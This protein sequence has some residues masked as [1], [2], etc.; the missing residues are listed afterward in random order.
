MQACLSA[1]KDVESSFHNCVSPVKLVQACLCAGNTL[2]RRFNRR[3]GAVK[4]VQACLSARNDLEAIFTT[5][6]IL[7]NPWKLVCVRKTPY[8]AIY[9]PEV[10]L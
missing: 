8:N 3:R 7:F 6:E 2:Q 1:R 5:V 10:V 4:H 9:T